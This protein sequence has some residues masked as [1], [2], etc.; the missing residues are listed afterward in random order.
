[1][2]VVAILA[3]LIVVNYIT[4]AYCLWAF[5]S[6]TTSRLKV[7]PDRITNLPLIVFLTVGLLLFMRYQVV[8]DEF[9]VNL[10]R[11]NPQ[12]EKQIRA[13]KVFLIYAS[14]SVAMMFVVL[15]SVVLIGAR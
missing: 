5:V 13:R 11:E 8:T 2:Q 15:T 3:T 4:F 10:A 1:M 14:V 12:H 7:H 6:T 9:L